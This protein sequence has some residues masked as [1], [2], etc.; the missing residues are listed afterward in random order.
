M[1]RRAIRRASEDDSLKDIS[2][3]QFSKG[4]QESKIR[5]Q[6][7]GIDDEYSAKKSYGEAFVAAVRK[8]I[9]C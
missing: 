8:Q 6:G 3:L 4:I 5:L 2:G 9:N 1:E 7:T